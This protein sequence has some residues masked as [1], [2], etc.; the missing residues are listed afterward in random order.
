MTKQEQTVNALRVWGSALLGRGAVEV[1]VGGVSVANPPK[2]N[3]PQDGVILVGERGVLYADVVDD[4]D[5]SVF[6]PWTNVLWIEDPEV[7]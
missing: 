4:Q 2:L 1:R 6:V 5:V 3:V 7:P